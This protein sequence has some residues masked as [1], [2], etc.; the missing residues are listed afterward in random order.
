MALLTVFHFVLLKILCYFFVDCHFNC[1]WFGNPPVASLPVGIS[2]HSSSTTCSIGARQALSEVIRPIIVF[3]ASFFPYKSALPLFH[4]CNV[5]THDLLLCYERLFSL[6]TVNNTVGQRY[7]MYQIHR[8]H[9]FFF[10]TR[11]YIWY[12][13]VSNGWRMRGKLVAAK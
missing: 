7:I 2:A 8:Y 5:F 12:G 1:V 13:F 10:K 4:A 6:L 3:W 11:E 9:L